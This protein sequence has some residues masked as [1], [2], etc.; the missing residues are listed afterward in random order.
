LSDQ[1]PDRNEENDDDWAPAEPSHSRTLARLVRGKNINETSL[2]AT[3]YLNHFNEIIMLIELIP[4]MPDCLVEAKAWQPKSYAQHFR[5]SS[6]NDKELAI[7]AFEN[8]P[9]RFREPFDSAVATLDALVI[10]GLEKID[11]AV[12]S[13][14]EELLAD[15]A[16]NLS[17]T[18][19]QFVDV[20]SA[21]INGDEM[22]VDQAKIDQIING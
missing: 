14:N 19:R 21:I 15:T 22:T 10:Q 17:H 20:A 2:L 16:A 8:S 4:S 11:A 6:F 1:V 13:G 7:L 5:D 3:D 18:L 12:D 9:P